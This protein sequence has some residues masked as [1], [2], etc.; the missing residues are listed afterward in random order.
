MFQRFAAVCS[1]DF[2]LYPDRGIHEILHN[3]YMSGGLGVPWQN[4]GCVALF[5][6]GWAKSDTFDL[7]F[8]GIRIWGSFQTGVSS[9]LP[10]CRFF[11]ISEIIID[12]CI[13]SI[14]DCREFRRASKRSVRKAAEKSKRENAGEHNRTYVRMFRLACFSL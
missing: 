1:P 2:S 7:R 5:T 4:Y 10:N 12:Y 3:I 11:L 6:V 9:V 8:G 13:P 14:G